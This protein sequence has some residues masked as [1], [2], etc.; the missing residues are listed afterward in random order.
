M[1]EPVTVAKPLWR[2]LIG[3]AVIVALMALGF[4]L[5]LHKYLTLESIAANRAALQ[6][7]TDQH[8]F[9]ALGLF[10]LIYIAAVALSFPGASVL[11]ILAGLLFGWFAGGAAAVISAT[12]GAVILFKIVNTSFGDVLVKKAGPMLSRINAGFA[13]DAFNYLLFLRLV[14]A[15][16]FWLVNIAPALANVKLRTFALATLIGIIPGTFAF[17]FVG[18]GLDSLITA[19]KAIHDTCVV[20]KGASACPFELSV[21]SLITKEL[22]I[23][24]AVLGVVSLIPVALKKWKNAHV[25]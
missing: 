15:F 1:D 10:M 23:A 14:P 2:R 5:G 7:Y 3:P 16:P 6:A 8:L 17:A 24:F 25:V 9:L 13:A 12:I 20:A 4:S 21:S 18:E 19:Q 11:T 22:L